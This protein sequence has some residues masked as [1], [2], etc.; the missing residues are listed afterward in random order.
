MRLN[1]LSGRRRRAVF[2]RTGEGARPSA[3]SSSIYFFAVGGKMLFKR[4]YID[5]SA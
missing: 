1:P 5:A 2:G 4:K 3:S